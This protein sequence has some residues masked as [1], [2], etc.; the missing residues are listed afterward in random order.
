MNRRERNKQR[1]K[2]A[3]QDRLRKEKH[4]RESPRGKE[5][6]APK[7]P[8]L[9]DLPGPPP[10][11]PS[12]PQALDRGEDARRPTDR[13]AAEASAS[14]SGAPSAAEQDNICTPTG[15][16]DD[17]FRG[18]AAREW[19]ARLLAGTDTFTIVETLEP[20]SYLPSHLLLKAS[21]CCEMLV[22]AELVAAGVGRP[23]R[24]LPLPVLAWLIERDVLF[25]PGV[26]AMAAAAVRRVGEFSELR[27]LLDT[28]RLS[29]AWLP[30]VEALHSRLL[31]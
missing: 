17:F 25:S 30:G 19:L 2:T 14:N 13:D 5:T 31:G 8:S 18:K 11:G 22:A 26:V 27:H 23:S 9:K 21:V 6:A 29:E 16:L 3:R 1:K 20:V 28:V 15:P 4:R 24:H 10:V 7:H 12:L